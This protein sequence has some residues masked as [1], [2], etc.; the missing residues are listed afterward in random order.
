MEDKNYEGT[1][2]LDCF[3]KYVNKSFAQNLFLL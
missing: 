1:L 2:I 3:I